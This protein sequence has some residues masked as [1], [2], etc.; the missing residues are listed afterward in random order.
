MNL[1]SQKKRIIASAEQKSPNFVYV[2]AAIVAITGCLGLA[3]VFEKLSD[4]VNYPFKASELS[5][6]TRIQVQKTL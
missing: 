5:D 6:R 2:I 4:K 1:Q 3:K